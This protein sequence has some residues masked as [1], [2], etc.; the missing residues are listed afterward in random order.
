MRTVRCPIEDNE[1]GPTGTIVGC[2]HV[3]DALPDDDGIVDCPNCGLF[4]DPD[5]PNSQPQP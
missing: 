5:H 1:P 2:G 3:F 4:F